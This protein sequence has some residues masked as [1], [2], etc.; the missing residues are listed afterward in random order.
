MKNWSARTCTPFGWPSF[1][2]NVSGTIPNGTVVPVL[3]AGEFDRRR[4]NLVFF[5]GREGWIVDAY[6][7]PV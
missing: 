1:N 3:R 4:W 7:K 5:D 6:T 2:P